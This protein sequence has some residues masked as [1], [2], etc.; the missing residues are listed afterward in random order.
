[1]CQCFEW[2]CQC[3]CRSTTNSSLLQCHCRPS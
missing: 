2:A 3:C 1:M